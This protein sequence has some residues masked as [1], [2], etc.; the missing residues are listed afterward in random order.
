MIAINVDRCLAGFVAETSGNR[1]RESFLAAFEAHISGNHSGAESVLHSLMGEALDSLPRTERLEIIGLRIA[2]FIA[3]GAFARAEELASLMSTDCAE[4]GDQRGQ[5]LAL[6]SLAAISALQ[7]HP[8][9]ARSLGVR[10]RDL[11]ARTGS[12]SEISRA[13]T[14]LGYASVI[15]GELERGIRELEAAA[16]LAEAASSPVLLAR[17]CQQLG[18]AFEKLG[19]FDVAVKRFEEARLSYSSV[20]AVRHELH[21]RFALASLGGL[22]G[23][24]EAI[25]TQMRFAEPYFGSVVVGSSLARWRLLAAW[26]LVQGSQ[27]ET[28]VEALSACLESLVAG[29]SQRDLALC[30]EFLADAR[31]GLKDYVKA[32]YH[33][34]EGLKLGRMIAPTSDVTLECLWKSGELFLATNR[35]AEALHRARQA[36]LVARLSK[37]RFERAAVVR[38][39]GKIQAARGRNKL[40]EGLLTHAW[41]EYLAMGAEVDAAK[42]AQLLQQL[43]EPRSAQPSG[44]QATPGP[45]GPQIRIQGRSETRKEIR[46]LELEAREAG[47]V[48]VDPRVLEAYRLAVKAAETKLPVL[49]LGETGTGKELFAS[50]IHL[51]SN[52]SRSFVPVNCAALPPD[53]LDAELFGHARGAFTGALRDRPGLVEEANGGTLFLD[54][55]GEM[56][57]AVQGRL[58]RAV[59]QGEIRRIGETKP[60]FVSTR[61]VAATHRDLEE[62]VRHHTFRT[63]LFF[64]LQGVV[65]RIPPLRDRAQDIDLLLDHYL[66]LFGTRMKRRI[67]LTDAAKERLRTH[68]WPGNVRELRSLIDRLVSLNDEGA[69]LDDGDLGLGVPKTGSSLAEHLEE[70][71][72]RRLT[73][74]LESV[75]WNQSAAARTLRIK[76]TTLLG[77][78]KRLGIVGPRK[79]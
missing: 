78:M 37:N 58:L 72:R 20:G 51:R 27:W 73:A 25:Q 23:A 12:A 65:I 36:M 15:G 34:E 69:E 22:L 7:G 67:W 2:N 44:R 77:K 32:E 29:G 47:I 18:Y 35:F 26:C 1:L 24:H 8:E 14:N 19:Q 5:G 53:L 60:R 40:A 33:Y 30:H 74:I 16:S 4:H 42:T 59:E 76:R 68:P 49:I 62:M 28:A 56:T 61:Y 57:L 39:R 43:H 63:D 31:L 10:A 6:T 79:K 55:V 75:R 41:Q 52:T 66:T 21:A 54:E 71:E 48:S 50:L 11:L 45:L 46:A 17:A 38:L 9:Y 3:S 70:E 64:R 13:L